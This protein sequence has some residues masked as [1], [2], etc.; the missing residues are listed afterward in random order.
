MDE[1]MRGAITMSLLGRA[2]LIRRLI[3]TR[4]QPRNVN[5]TV[6]MIPS[7]ARGPTVHQVLGLVILVQ[8]QPL[9]SAAVSRTRCLL[10]E[11]AHTGPVWPLVLLLMAR[12]PQNVKLHLHRPNHPLAAL[13]LMG[14]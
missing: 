4:L 12:S 8:S 13:H 3:T 1:T 14:N 6:S 11:L 9:V 10:K 5:P 2:V 7:A